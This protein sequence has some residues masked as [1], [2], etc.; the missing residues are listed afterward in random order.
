MSWQAYVDSNMVGTGKISR[1]A[2]HGH[3]GSLWATSAGFTVSPADFQEIFS[4][5]KDATNIRTNG[6][7]VGGVK[8][9][10]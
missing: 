10:I 9:H 2:I 7:H 6:L 3:D 8:V 1:A 5:Y 4:A